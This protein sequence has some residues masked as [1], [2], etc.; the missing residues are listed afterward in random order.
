MS[1]YLPLSMPISR[2]EVGGPL[3][4]LPSPP[5]PMASGF[6]FGSSRVSEVEGLLRLRTSLYEKVLAALS[7]DPSCGS[8]HR[9][10]HLL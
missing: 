3:P 1:T 4:A 7:A 8:F 10:S 6:G 2:R 9:K 5:S